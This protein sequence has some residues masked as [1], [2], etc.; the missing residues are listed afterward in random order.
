[1]VEKTDKP[2]NP[3]K[4]GVAWKQKDKNGNDLISV[5]MEDG[6]KF[7]LIKNNFKKGEKQPDMIA[8]KYSPKE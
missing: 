2:K 1:M 5:K 8:M 3:N 6:T 7:S 4:I